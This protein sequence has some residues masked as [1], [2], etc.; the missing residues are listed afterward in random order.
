MILRFIL[1][2]LL[3]A[4]V[5]NVYLFHSIGSLGV[6][7]FLLILSFIGVFGYGIKRFSATW[8]IV[9]ILG[10][11][12][13]LTVNRGAL[14]PQLLLVLGMVLSFIVLWYVTLAKKRFINSFSELLLVP[15]TLF[16]AYRIAIW[17]SVTAIISLRKQ[18]P[19]PIINTASEW[20]PSIIV[21]III[22]IPLVAV[23]L[24]LLRNA[25]PI[26]NKTIGNVL[27][28]ITLSNTSLRII[29]GLISFF[30]VIPL[31]FMSLK[32]QN[33]QVL[34]VNESLIKPITVVMTMIA[35]TLVLFLIIQWPYIFVSVAK[36]YEL[37]NY[38]ISTYSEYVKRGFGEFL[39]TS[40]IVY[41]FLWVGILSLRTF[42]GTKRPLLFY[43]QTV[44]TIIF[45][46]FLISIFRR[47]LLYWEFHGLTVIRLYGSIFLLWVGFLGSTLFLRSIKKYT[48]IYIE[49]AVTICFLIAIGYV[50]AEQFIVRHHPPT[51]N[52]TI[53]I[54]YLSRLSTDGY[55]GWKIAY[56]VS[57]EYL[58][59][60]HK[61]EGLLN[62]EDRR[63]AAYSG[64]SLGLLNREYYQLIS[65]HGSDAD[66][67]EYTKAVM[68]SFYPEIIQTVSVFETSMQTL[69]Q[70]GEKATV[71]ADLFSSQIG[72]NKVDT[73]NEHLQQ[74]R[75]VASHSAEL[76][77]Q[78]NLHQYFYSIKP[79]SPLSLVNYSNGMCAAYYLVNE[80]V[81]AGSLCV[82]GFFTIT[83]S[84]N[85]RNTI[86]YVL[87]WNRRNQKVF[88]LIK[89]EIPIKD[90]IVLQEQYIDIWKRI[91][92]QTKEERYYLRDI[93]Y[94][95][96][97][98]SPLH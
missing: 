14:F 75:A 3:L 49:S 34:D 17:R 63:K 72:P 86:E 73:I 43:V 59:E 37:T 1:G 39:I 81:K 61:K 91:I 53:D 46:V 40:F 12:G 71:S 65:V 69:Q 4:G 85:K 95:A 27:S 31:A 94:D 22:G 30:S 42:K 51:V 41:S 25:D 88:S 78:S 48:W 66:K 13:W 33:S 97:L 18:S 68:S 44:V 58:S 9:V 84:Y 96:P 38:G 70:Q 2:G 67:R 6:V 45:L 89:Q 11:L 50:N 56:N 8:Y 32:R 10:L 87:N 15:V 24:I 92:N 82:P 35:L 76:L 57:K 54:V 77:N 47:V 16:N 83:T 26:F 55:E 60:L 93:S 80:P 64:L 19:S 7:G 36:E 62:E 98:L 79:R 23:L 29:I 28:Y 21:G 90:V 52:N 74:L 20:I 5:V